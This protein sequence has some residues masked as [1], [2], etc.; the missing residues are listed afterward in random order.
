MYKRNIVVL[1]LSLTLALTA[2]G[3]GSRSSTSTTLNIQMSDFAFS[4]SEFSVPAGAEITLN[5]SNLGVVEHQFVIMKKGAEVTPPFS[6]DDRPSIYW[7]TKLES[8]ND[9]S[10]KFT[11]PS[12]PGE[13]QI[14]CGVPGH[15][16]AGMVA[17]LIVK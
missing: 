5:L 15:L 12:V 9:E 4:P 2:C 16:E 8:G 14:V 7:E 11:A 17:K 13:Y 10:V 3:T 1:A 6:E